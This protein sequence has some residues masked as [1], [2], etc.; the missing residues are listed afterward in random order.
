MITVHGE[1]DQAG[2]GDDLDPDVD[3]ICR[4]LPEVELGTSW[5]DV[6]TYK[7]RDKGFLL[8]RAAAQVRDRSGDR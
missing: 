5:G 2:A 6:A 8:Y 4:A 1:G 7:V 3:A